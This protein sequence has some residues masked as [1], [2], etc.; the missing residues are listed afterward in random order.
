MNDLYTCTICGS[1]VS[2]QQSVA[3]KTGRACRTHPEAVEASLARLKTEQRVRELNGRTPVGLRRHPQYPS[4]EETLRKFE[5]AKE[6]AKSDHDRCWVCGK[7]GIHVDRWPLL[8]LIAI[9]ML[10]TIEY[11]INLL[12]LRGQV[13]ELLGLSAD[14]FVTN[15]QR[16]TDTS[17][18]LCDDDYY[19]F[20]DLQGS[21]IAC[22]GCIVKHHL[23]AIQSAD[24]VSTHLTPNTVAAFS[25]VYNF[26]EHKT[27]VR[28]VAGR[29][30]ALKAMAAATD[31]R[32]ATT[33]AGIQD[34]KE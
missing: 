23:A 27:E 33:I 5:E 8:V 30:R 11:P 6:K 17:L 9:E 16:T 18:R 20:A 29:L 32:A 7:M 31:V 21:V 14:M 28:E 26:S 25:A 4:S 19:N 22:R 34:R 1:Q 2:K 3:Y 12:D 15:A 24:P 13:M 10:N